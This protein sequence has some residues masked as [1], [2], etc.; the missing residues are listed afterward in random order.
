[1][2]QPL[3]FPVFVQM[4]YNNTE[5]YTPELKLLW[6]YF[7]QEGLAVK[8]SAVAALKSVRAA[9]TWMLRLLQ[10]KSILVIQM[11][12][13]RSAELSVFL[14]YYFFLSYSSPCLTFTWYPENSASPACTHA[15]F[16]CHQKGE[17]FF[18][19]Y[20]LSHCW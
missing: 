16:Y 17:I 9:L 11:T 20:L 3:C 2:W 19:L 4:E 15:M 13:C 10:L 1:M 8:C 7:E 18:F 14:C 12:Q 6:F 5:N